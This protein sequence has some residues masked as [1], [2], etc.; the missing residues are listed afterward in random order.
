MTLRLR[1]RFQEARNLRDLH[2]IKVEEFNKITFLIF[3]TLGYGW[4]PN[5]Q[6]RINAPPLN[7]YIDYSARPGATHLHFAG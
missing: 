5:P 3:K 6:K 1:P 2:M 7:T 4:R